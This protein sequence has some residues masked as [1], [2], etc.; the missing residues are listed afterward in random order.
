[1]DIVLTHLHLL[2]Q[3]SAIKVPAEDYFR[4]KLVEVKQAG[5]Q[6]A[7]RAKKVRHMIFGFH[8]LLK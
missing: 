3:G 6:W 7:E 1:M 5:M 2:S 4:Q 8:S